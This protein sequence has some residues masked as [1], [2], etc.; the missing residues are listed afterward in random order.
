[1]KPCKREGVTIIEL[2]LTIA[3]F[4]LVIL[5]GFSLLNLS[6]KPLAIANQEVDL[7]SYTRSAITTI[8]DYIEKASAI[9]IHG[10]IENVFTDNDIYPPSKT[11]SEVI[12]LMKTL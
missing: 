11:T 2:L 3:L 5:V 1:M 9:F 10:D 4:S 7:Q 8:I 6:S 12:R